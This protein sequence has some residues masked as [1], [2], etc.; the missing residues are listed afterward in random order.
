[1]TITIIVIVLILLALLGAKQVF[2]KQP[3]S[4]QY[5]DDRDEQIRQFREE[6]EAAYHIQRDREDQWAEEQRRLEE[7]R[8][9]MEQE[10]S[11]NRDYD[12]GW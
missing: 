6:Q 2:G 4:N 3:S 12:N 10:R 11:R 1:M 8:Y 9:E 5:Y 7:E